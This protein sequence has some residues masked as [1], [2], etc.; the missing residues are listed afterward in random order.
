MEELIYLLPKRA[1]SLHISSV[2]MWTNGVCSVFDT[3][4]DPM[5][6]LQGMFEKV[7]PFIN[8]VFSG[9]WEY[10]DWAERWLGKACKQ[11]RTRAHVEV[12][13][14]LQTFKQVREEYESALQLEDGRW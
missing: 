14:I 12:S 3:N 10:G 9:V 1:A 11:P 6:E 2:I 4:G 7:A 5:P 8:A 13:A